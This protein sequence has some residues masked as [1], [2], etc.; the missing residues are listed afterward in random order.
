MSMFNS[1]HCG[2]L[3]RLS[4]LIQNIDYIDLHKKKLDTMVTLCKH[5]IL[6]CIQSILIQNKKGLYC[7]LR[8]AMYSV[9][10]RPC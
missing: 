1:S 6:I 3:Q 4:K 9:G 2:E 7:F 10:S 8:V 5:Q